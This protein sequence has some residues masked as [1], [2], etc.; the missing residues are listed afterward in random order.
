MGSS[1]SSTRILRSDTPHTEHGVEGFRERHQLGVAKLVVGTRKTK[2]FHRHYEAQKIDFDPALFGCLSI[3]LGDLQRKADILSGYT[4]GN[5]LLIVGPYWSIVTPFRCALIARLCKGERMLLGG[6]TLRMIAEFYRKESSLDDMLGWTAEASIPDGTNIKIDFMRE[7]ADSDLPLQLR[8][9][10]PFFVGPWFDYS[11]VYRDV[12]SAGTVT[13]RVIQGSLLRAI[14]RAST[15][16][17]K[18]SLSRSRSEKAVI[19]LV[20]G[21]DCVTLHA[22]LDRVKDFGEGSYMHKNYNNPDYM[23]AASLDDVPYPVKIENVSLFT[24]REVR[25]YLGVVDLRRMVEV[26][27]QNRR[28]A[29]REVAPEQAEID[30]VGGWDDTLGFVFSTGTTI[31][32]PVLMHMGDSVFIQKTWSVKEDK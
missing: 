19:E 10:Q 20:L 12:L 25:K 26:W 11:K 17:K 1:A 31:D 30:K 24:N 8:I 13:G 21:H 2:L 32:S 29:K 23:G 6:E 5:D 27:T 16:I 7:G 15:R 9:E 14:S 22:V 4:D 28:L 3:L 18:S